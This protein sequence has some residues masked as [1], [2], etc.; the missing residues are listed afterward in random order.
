[1]P[2]DSNKLRRV[3]RILD[4][5]LNSARNLKLP[6]QDKNRLLNWV[7]NISPYNGY[8]NEPIEKPVLV[9]NWNVPNIFSSKEDQRKLDLIF[10][11]FEMALEKAGATLEWSYAVCICDCCNKPVEAAQYQMQDSPYL[12]LVNSEFICFRCIAQDPKEY[13]ESIEDKAIANDVKIDLTAHGYQKVYR[14]PIELSGVTDI[15]A[16]LK[17]RLAQ[18]QEMGLRRIIFNQVYRYRRFSNIKYEVYAHED[19]PLAFL[20]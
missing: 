20:G 9:G 8:A 1:M 4:L 3:N 12:K 11:R 15:D 5:A 19:E 13:L 10:R 17:K 2:I 18:L 6:V 14:E 7:E 16:E